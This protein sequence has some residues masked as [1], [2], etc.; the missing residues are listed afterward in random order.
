MND[1]W[2]QETIGVLP[3]VL[4]MFFGIGIPYGLALLPR[5]DWQYRVRVV[6]VGMLAGSALLTAWMF[7]LGTIGSL[8]GEAWLRLDSVF[9]GSVVITLIGCVLVFYRSRQS[10]TL[11]T[12]NQPFALDEKVLIF[13]IIIALLMR[14]I[15]TKI[16]TFSSKAKG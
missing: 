2:L 8:R 13:V 11:D 16:R 4:W 14:W 6:V 7:I 10:Y 5:R 12:E 1:M 9:I 3:A 15:V